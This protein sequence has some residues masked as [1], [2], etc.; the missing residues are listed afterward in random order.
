MAIILK[1]PREI[2]LMKAAG[3][4]VSGVFKEIKPW[5]RPGVST[6]T[7][8]DV[9]ERYIRSKGAT[10]TFKGYGG[11]S[12]AICTSVNDIIIHGIP[13]KHVIL[14]EGD[15]ISCDVGATL[16]GYVGDA[17]RT[18]GVGKISKEAEELIKV[19][20]ESFFEAIK[21]IKPGV[22]LGDISNKIQEVNESHGYSLIKDYTGHGVG[23]ELHEDPYIPNY[24]PKGV[25]PILRAGMTLAIEPMVAMGSDKVEVLK[26]GWGVR[27]KDHKL[28]AHYE[29]SIAILEDEVIILTLTPEE[30]DV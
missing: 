8:A 23:H 16:N 18:F 7:I 24:G 30:L 29:N 11:F 5:I 25:G 4:V 17:C 6:K 21:L 14:K 2:E 12:G 13:S 28:S 27:M 15:I 3:A 26:D 19:T 1:S 20:E 22:H 10:P 9:A